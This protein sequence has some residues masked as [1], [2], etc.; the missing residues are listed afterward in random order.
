M[1]MVDPY[2]VNF[3]EEPG[4]EIARAIFEVARE[5]KRSNDIELVD[6]VMFNENED[7]FAAYV[8][9]QGGKI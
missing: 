6:R 5:L 8:A 9:E 3:G 7:K 4:Y 2:K 1:S